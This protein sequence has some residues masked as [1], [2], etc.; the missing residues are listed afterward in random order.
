M[1]TCLHSLECLKGSLLSWPVTIICQNSDNHEDKQLF[2]KRQTKAWTDEPTQKA[3]RRA[4]IY[5][6][7]SSV[8]WRNISTY[9]HMY[10]CLHVNTG[11]SVDDWWLVMWRGALGF[12]RGLI[13]LSLTSNARKSTGQR[14]APSVLKTKSKTQHT[15]HNSTS[16]PVILHLQSEGEPITSNTCLHLHVSVQTSPI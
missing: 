2:L 15:F 10:M 8:K 14:K 9:K 6:S 3:A 12:R 4:H 13:A 5:F 11:L 7:L 1:W 16:A